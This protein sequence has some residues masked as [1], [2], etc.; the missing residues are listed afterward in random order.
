[1]A[2]FFYTQQDSQVEEPAAPRRGLK[3]VKG[4][5]QHVAQPGNGRASDLGD[6]IWSSSLSQRRAEVQPPTLFTRTRPAWKHWIVG[7]WRWLWDLDEVVGEAHAEPLQG[8][9]AVKN[10][11]NTAMWDL[12]SVRA[13]Q[14]RDLISQA[15]SLRE[16][17][18]LRAD[19][20]RVVALH[21]G[22]AEAELRMEA[23]D[24]HFPVRASRRNE[25]TRNTKVTTW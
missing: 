18:H 14:V 25:D 7:A 6:S 19:V 20:F 21:R 3:L 10:E 1:M 22:Q 4:G 5:V 23:L 17:W 16:L 24:A 2:S 13:N 9:D 11:F 8:M 12:Q 15:R